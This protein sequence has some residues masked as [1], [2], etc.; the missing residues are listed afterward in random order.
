MTYLYYVNYSGK[1]QSSIAQVAL[2]CP[3]QVTPCLP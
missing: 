2:H 3:M 1:C